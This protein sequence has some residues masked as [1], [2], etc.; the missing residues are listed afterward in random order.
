MTDDVTYIINKLNELEIDNKTNIR[1]KFDVLIYHLYGPN[2]S[3][4]YEEG[5]DYYIDF[6][7]LNVY[8]FTQN[9]Y[10]FWYENKGIWY[11]STNPHFWNW[12]AFTYPP[13]FIGDHLVIYDESKKKTFISLDE[14]I[15]NENEWIDSKWINGKV[16]IVGSFC[17]YQDND[18]YCYYVA[19]ETSIIF[20]KMIKQNDDKK[21]IPIEHIDKIKTYSDDFLVIESDLKH[22]ISEYNHPYEFYEIDHEPY[23]ENDAAHAFYIASSQE[24]DNEYILA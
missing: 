10:W 5:N 21:F 12:I 14:D 19:H 23:D 2:M 7:K 3:V 15:N 8:S 18:D 4:F 24:E 22:Y 6:H 20:E 17:Y 13:K 16:I 9:Y 1:D 11:Y